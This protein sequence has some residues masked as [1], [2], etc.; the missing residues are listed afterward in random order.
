MKRRCHMEEGLLLA[1]LEH[2]TEARGR[3]FNYQETFCRDPFF[4]SNFDD[5]CLD[6]G[7]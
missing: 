7:S 4:R 3:F 2:P 6:F 1:G 5:Q